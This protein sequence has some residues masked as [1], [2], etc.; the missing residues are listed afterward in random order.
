M[1]Q[2]TI[3]NPSSDF[4]QMQN[5]VLQLLAEKKIT[6]S[7]Y[8]LYGFYC[9]VNGWTKLEMGYEYISKNTGLSIGNISKC[10]RLLQQNKLIAIFGN[11]VNVNYEI[12]IKDPR[13]L[14]KRQLFPVE[15]ATK[16]SAR[17]APAAT[18]STSAAQAAK[19]CPGVSPS[20][21]EEDSVSQDETPVSN[22]ESQ[23]VSVSPGEAT[24]TG[25]ETESLQTK[26]T[27]T[28]AEPLSKEQRHF[29]DT[30]TSTW[31]EKYG[32]KS[33]LKD[34][35]SKV[36][37]IPDPVEALKYIPVLWSLGE[38]D[39][40]VSKSDHTLTVFVKE[41]KAGKLQACYPDTIHWLA[42]QAAAQSA[43]A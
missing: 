10:N 11:G 4:H 38:V 19:L 16:G 22:G 31:C 34:D 6:T 36:L 43:R 20:E 35:Y 27:T 37:E 8:A 1:A 18:G 28:G 17:S 2:V 15:R 14:P 5:Y 29:I 30:F 42:D 32:T 7:A 9:S 3:V 39:R 33:Y 25:T 21:N 24:Y 40:W 23:T 41:L 12:R 13:K 26:K